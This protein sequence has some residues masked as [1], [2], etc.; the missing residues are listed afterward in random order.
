[1]DNIGLFNRSAPLPP[2]YR[3]EQSD[4]TSWM[5]FYCQQMFKIALE[6][7]RHDQAWDDMATKFLEHFLSIAKAMNT[8]GSHDMSL[9]ARGRRVLLRRAGRTRTAR[10]ST[11]GC[12]RWSGCCRILGATEVPALDRRREPRR[13]PPGCAGCSGAGPNWWARCVAG[14]G[15]A[16]TMLLSLVDPERLRRILERLFDSGRVPVVVRHPIAVGR[17]SRR[18]PSS[19]PSARSACIDYEPGRV[20]H[21]RCS[22]A[23]RTGAD[24]SGSRSTCCS[25]TSCARTAASSAT[26]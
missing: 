21:R 6:L 25:P 13:R 7:S 12:G 8:F 26:R 14:T 24:R 20:D 16:A 23:T 4:A 1:M 22:A 18:R 5:A 15:P 19:R 10:R 3:L 17:L 9:V 2:G 11:C